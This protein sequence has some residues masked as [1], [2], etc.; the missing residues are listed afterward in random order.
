VRDDV[1]KVV[2]KLSKVSKCPNCR[3]RANEIDAARQESSIKGQI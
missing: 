3:L 2:K 1:K